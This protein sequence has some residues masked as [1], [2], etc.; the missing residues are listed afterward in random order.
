M[1]NIIQPTDSKHLPLRCAYP[2]GAEHRLEKEI[3]AIRYME[4]VKW[5]RT[6]T[7]SIRRGFM[8]ELFE[9]KGIFQ[10]FKDACWQNGNTP[11]GECRSRRYLRINQRYDDFLSGME[12]PRDPEDDITIAKR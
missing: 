1:E 6:Y 8:I 11:E 4:I 2:F 9:A 12:G 10:A 3:F 7:S 5:D